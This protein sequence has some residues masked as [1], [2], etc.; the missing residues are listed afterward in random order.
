MFD[1]PSIDCDSNDADKSI[2]L[3]LDAQCYQQVHGE[4]HLKIT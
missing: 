1:I 4:M 2:I 3:V